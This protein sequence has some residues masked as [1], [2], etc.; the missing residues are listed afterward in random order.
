MQDER[1]LPISSEREKNKGGKCIAR[2]SLRNEDVP[3]PPIKTFPPPSLATF[4]IHSTSVND[5]KKAEAVVQSNTYT[6]SQ[7]VD[8]RQRV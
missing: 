8:V 5:G 2:L 4:D 6:H 7:K 3:F 1:T